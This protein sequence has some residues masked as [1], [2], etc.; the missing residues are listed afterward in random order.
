VSCV[1]LCTSLL[2]HYEQPVRTPCP[3]LVLG[4]V[5]ELDN[6]GLAK[7]RGDCTA[8][9]DELADTRAGHCPYTATHSHP[10]SC[11]SY[12][13]LTYPASPLTSIQFVLASYFR[14]TCRPLLRSTQFVLSRTQAGSSHRK[15]RRVTIKA[16]Q[17]TDVG[18]TNYETEE[19]EEAA[20]VYGFT[21]SNT[22]GNG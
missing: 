18:Y 16:R 21:M 10:K 8:M 6:D 1:Q 22:S 4:N 20:S 2:V 12:P 9:W 5:P 14:S 17:V 7:L 11:S 15:H 13:L 19:V 3:T